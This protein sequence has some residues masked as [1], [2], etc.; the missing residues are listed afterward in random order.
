MSSRF[1]IFTKLGA[2]ASTAGAIALHFGITSTVATVPGCASDSEG[3]C[4]LELADATLDD[5]KVYANGVGIVFDNGIELIS[6][7][8]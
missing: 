1:A 3:K 8:P 5:E 6:V 7:T 4:S 2:L